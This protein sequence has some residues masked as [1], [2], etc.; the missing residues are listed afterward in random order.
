[1]GVKLPTQNCILPMLCEGSQFKADWLIS[2]EDVE[3]VG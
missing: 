2:T 3:Q 1:M